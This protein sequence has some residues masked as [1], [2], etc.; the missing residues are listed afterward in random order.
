MRGAYV[1][2]H[3]WNGYRFGLTTFISLSNWIYICV[4][5][6]WFFN[7]LNLFISTHTCKTCLKLPLDAELS[8]FLRKLTFLTA[9]NNFPKTTRAVNVLF[10]LSYYCILHTFHTRT[11]HILSLVRICLFSSTEWKNEGNCQILITEGFSPFLFACVQF[12]SFVVYRPFDWWSF[13]FLFIYIY[14]EYSR[15]MLSSILNSHQQNST[16]ILDWIFNLYKQSIKTI[17]YCLNDTIT[18]R[19]QAIP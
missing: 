14:I 1:R 4:A 16:V 12:Q 13:Y 8:I 5:P 6:S 7:S 9:V 3:W 10:I 19:N 2:G 15:T 11:T 17:S 18:T